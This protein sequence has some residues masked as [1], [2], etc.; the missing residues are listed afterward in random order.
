MR[1][2][3]IITVAVAYGVAAVF[4]LRAEAADKP[5]R[6]AVWKRM[7]PQEKAEQHEKLK[8]MIRDG[9]KA[10]KGQGEIAA[11]KNNASK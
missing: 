11:N 7:S 2:L 5:D 9:R 10:A 1:S 4:S 3:L 6:V 8:Q